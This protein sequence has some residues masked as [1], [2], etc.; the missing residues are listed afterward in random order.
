MHLLSQFTLGTEAGSAFQASAFVE[1]VKKMH[2]ERD[3]GFEEEFKVIQR[4]HKYSVHIF[5]M[6]TY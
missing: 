6:N 4:E 1:E 5:S 3:K 2:E